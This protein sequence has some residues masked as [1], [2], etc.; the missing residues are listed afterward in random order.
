[1]EAPCGL[2]TTITSS[3]YILR[4]DRTHTQS[5]KAPRISL[6]KGREMRRCLLGHHWCVVVFG[7]VPAYCQHMSQKP[8]QNLKFFLPASNSLR[9]DLQPH[10]SVTCS[11]LWFTHF[12]PS[13]YLL[14]TATQ[15]LL[16]LSEN[17]IQV[18]VIKKTL[19]FR[20]IKTT[21]RAA[22]YWRNCW[23]PPK[24]SQRHR[25]TYTRWHFFEI[26]VEYQ[27]S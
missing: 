8:L 4:T 9:S 14:L 15:E 11:S 5:D 12:Q 19:L 13:H 26:R 10:P 22:M 20:M 6:N 24:S 1:M 21:G 17:R 3:P 2:S 7:T 18:V 25:E 27:G 16:C 23:N